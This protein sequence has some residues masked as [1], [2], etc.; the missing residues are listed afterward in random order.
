[1][2]LGPTISTTTKRCKVIK[3]SS[4]GSSQHPANSGHPSHPASEKNTYFFIYFYIKIQIFNFQHVIM[5]KILGWE[6]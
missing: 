1:M 3:I 2:V 6:Q 4:P 5:V